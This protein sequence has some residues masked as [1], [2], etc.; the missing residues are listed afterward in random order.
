LSNVVTPTRKSLEFKHALQEHEI[1]KYMKEDEDT[2]MA[3]VESIRVM[4][5]I[6]LLWWNTSFWDI[7]M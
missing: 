5:Q 3:V 6:R 4:A 2:Y 7:R 1:R